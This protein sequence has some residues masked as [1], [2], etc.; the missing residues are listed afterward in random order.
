MITFNAL[1]FI[2]VL[3]FFGLGVFWILSLRSQIARERDRNAE[4][5]ARYRA[6]TH[7]HGLD[8]DFN[9]P[10]DERPIA[11]QIAES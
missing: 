3:L 5:R 6:W 9:W 8:P 1:V 10:M 7:I 11:S 2:P 4:L